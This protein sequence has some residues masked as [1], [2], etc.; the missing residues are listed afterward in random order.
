MTSLTMRQSGVVKESLRLMHGI[1]VG[2]PR[3]VPSSGA[4]IDGHRVPP[5]VCT[6]QASS[7]LMRIEGSPRFDRLSLPRLRSIAI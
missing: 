7:F 3:V 2:P 4:Q 1:I 6:S 5:K